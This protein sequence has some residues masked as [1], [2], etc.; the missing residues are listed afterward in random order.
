V[1]ASRAPSPPHPTRHHRT[2]TD[3][4]SGLRRSVAAH[5]GWRFARVT[6]VCEAIARLRKPRARSRV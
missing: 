6:G 4:G 2:A 5:S 1:R 3:P